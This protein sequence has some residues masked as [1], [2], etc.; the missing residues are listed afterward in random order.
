MTVT[1]ADEFPPLYSPASLMLCPASG[2]RL[3]PTAAE[4]AGDTP[5]ALKHAA[6]SVD[7]LPAGLYCPLCRP[8]MLYSFRAVALH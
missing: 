1:E 8:E 3:P 2:L 5:G 7:G 6:V 4:S